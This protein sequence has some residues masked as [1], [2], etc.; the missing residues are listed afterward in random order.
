MTTIYSSKVSSLA[1]TSWPES[2]LENT[3][4]CPLCGGGNR[5]IL[6]E[7]L[8]DN[9]FYT[10][11]GKWSSWRC[12]ECQCSYLDPRPSQASIHKAYENYY[13]H[14]EPISNPSYTELSRF[15]K[16]RRTLANGY[17]NWRYSTKKTPTSRVGIPLLLCLWPLKNSI[18]RTYRHMPRIP[19][20]GGALLDVGCGNCSFLELAKSSGWSVVGVDPDEKAI[21]H[22]LKEGINVKQ[23][24]IEQFDG[25]ENLFDVITIN[26]VIEHMHDPVTVLK[27]CHRLL[28][29]TGQLWLETPNIDSFGHR[30]YMEN[31]RG[32]E[33]P[34]HLVLFNSNSL[35]RAL[36]N[37]GFT[38]IKNKSGLNAQ[39]YMTMASE[40]IKQG[41]PDGVTA[42]LNWTHYWMIRKNRFLE[43]I[44]PSRKE[45]LTMVA[46]K[47]V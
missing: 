22:G 9:I 1:D 39:L 14:Q 46:Y 45:V 17:I 19:A 6:H 40:A 4:K 20:G 3:L 25:E 34:R 8:I 33:P 37:A 13:T 12:L 21:T 42:S 16:L 5:A 32:L 44:F 29:P 18:D 23:G 27:A 31:W 2:E 10:A 7:R 36:V 28:K 26:H 35:V 47:D 38:R 30:Y 24:G 15:R 43:F 11:P 41:L